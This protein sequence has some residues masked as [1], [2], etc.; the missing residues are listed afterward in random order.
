M[1]YTYNQAPFLLYTQPSLSLPVYLNR[2]R[3]L[4]LAQYIFKHRK[5]LNPSLFKNKDHLATSR[6]VPIPPLK[7]PN[8]AREQFVS[9][10]ITTTPFFEDV[11]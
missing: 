3:F 9:L 8:S 11:L 4:F 7:L 2:Q 6:Q 5:R 1:F 10:P